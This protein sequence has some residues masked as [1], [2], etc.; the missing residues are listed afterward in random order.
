MVT[1]QQPP[2]V[3]GEGVQVP[4]AELQTLPASPGTPF[5]SVQ[6]SAVVQ[7]QKSSLP[8]WQQPNDAG[9]VLVVVVDAAVVVVLG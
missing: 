2:V 1:V 7:T 8:N 9:S 6:L 4:V 3:A 5:A